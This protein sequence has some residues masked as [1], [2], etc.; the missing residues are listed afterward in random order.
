MCMEL[1]AWCLA[2]S[3]VEV[4]IDE[5]LLSAT[6]GPENQDIMLRGWFSKGHRVGAR[7]CNSR[8]VM[9]RNKLICCFGLAT[10]DLNS[11]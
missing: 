2:H 7:E 3:E 1:S 8:D 6:T 4:T 9:H 10:T 11:S 5:Q